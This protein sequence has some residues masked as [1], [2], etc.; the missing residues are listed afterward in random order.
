MTPVYKTALLLVLILLIASAGTGL[1]LSRSSTEESVRIEKLAPSSDACRDGQGICTAR[2]PV[3]GE[4]Q[5][6]FPQGA[7]YMQPFIAEVRLENPGVVERV[8]L[9]LSMPGM[10]MGL[11]R[12]ELRRAGD[13]LWRGKL[14]L[15][16]CVTGRVDWQV[17]VQLDTPG[18]RYEAQFPLIVSQPPS[19]SD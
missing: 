17:R 13:G 6:R 16:I 11:N 10:E 12:F 4:M 18:R 8:V 3:F 19:K 7:Y 14:L 5:L 1:Y 15:P 9:D 2:N